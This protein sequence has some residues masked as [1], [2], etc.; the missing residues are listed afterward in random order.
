MVPGKAS[1]SGRY[2]SEFKTIH[3]VE[4]SPRTKAGLYYFPIENGYLAATSLFDLSYVIGKVPR[5]AWFGASIHYAFAEHY[6]WGFMH[7]LAMLVSDQVAVDAGVFD[8][9]TPAGRHLASFWEDPVEAHARLRLD[10]FS[11]DAFL[12]AIE[13]LWEV[14]LDCETPWIDDGRRNLVLRRK[15]P[16]ASAEGKPWQPEADH[17]AR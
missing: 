15:L 5:Y 2:G 16:P 9:D 13:A 14:E 4:P 11:Y 12:E 8:H 3:I 17:G 6:G 7:K 1:P 10:Q